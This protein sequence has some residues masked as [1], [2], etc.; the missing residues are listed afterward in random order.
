MCA[1]KKTTL[2]LI[3]GCILA[4]AFTANLSAQTLG[5]DPSLSSKT[6]T[7]TG[8]SSDLTQTTLFTAPATGDFL[9]TFYA[10]A[11]L[12]NGEDCIDSSVFWTDENGNEQTSFGIS[13]PGMAKVLPIHVTAASTVSVSTIVGSDFCGVPFT[14]TYEFVVSKTKLN[15]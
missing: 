14:G 5:G 9:L 8:L 2:L 3:V 6:W 15:P 10:S 7:W 1:M 4:I 12:T 11:T 13:T